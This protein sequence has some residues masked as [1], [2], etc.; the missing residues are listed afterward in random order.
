MESL[1]SVRKHGLLIKRA[2]QIE[3]HGRGTGVDDGKSR[4]LGPVGSPG[5]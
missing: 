3:A 1:Q 4:K 5:V 2:H